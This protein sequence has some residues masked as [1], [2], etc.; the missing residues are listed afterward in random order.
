MDPPKGS[1]KIYIGS[2][3]D[4]SKRLK[5]HLSPS[6]LNR[7]KTMYIFNA[8]LQHGY[9]AFSLSILEHIDLTNLSQEYPRKLILEREQFYIN[10]KFSVDKPNTDNSLKV[11]GSRLGSKLSEVTI[12]KMSGEK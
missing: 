4:I 10:K 5:I 6:Y 8:L 3:K 7:N 2:A 11:A 1:G 12:V 9:S